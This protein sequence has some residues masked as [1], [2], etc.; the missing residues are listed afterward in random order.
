MLEWDK[1]YLEKDPEHRH[2]S[3]L[4][5][6][7]PGNEITQDL[8]P[9]LFDA[10]KRSLEIRGDEGTGWAMAWKSCC[11]ARLKDGNHAY[12]IL[13]SL[14]TPGYTEPGII[15]N[16][17][18]SCPP[19]NIDGNFGGG[20]AIIEMLLQS[21]ETINM[22]GE[23]IPIIEILPALPDVWDKGEISGLRAASGFEVDMDWKEGV[24]VQARIQSL[25]GQ[26]VFLRYKARI[27]P[28]I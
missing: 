15:P 6:L 4:Y 9:E 12:T 13:S 20:A 23:E 25:F 8:T 16:M 19:F 5:G 17:L 24:L 21:H 26:K 3:H 18:A 28:L 1:E 2:I 7:S 22:D 10:V 11:W 14:F 27:F